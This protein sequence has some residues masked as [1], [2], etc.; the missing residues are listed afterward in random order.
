[1][2]KIMLIGGSSVL[3]ILVIASIIVTVTQ[4]EQPLAEGSPEA[5]VQGFL[6]ASESGETQIAYDFLSNELK[7]ECSLQSFGGRAF[8]RNRIEDSRIVLDK[9]EIIDTI[10]FVTVQVTQF[11]G[12]GPFGSSEST[13][14]EQFRLTKEANDWKLSQYSFPYYS[15]GPFGPVPKQLR[16]PPAHAP[17]ADPEPPEPQL[18]VTATPAAP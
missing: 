18:V 6:R 7:S 2:T 17:K 8:E 10:A 15:C 3:A 9:S 16:P 1:M 11:N 12:N 4:K 5:A 13:H 14:S